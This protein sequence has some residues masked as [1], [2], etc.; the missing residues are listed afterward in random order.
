MGTRSGREGRPTQIKIGWEK[1][2]NGDI[3]KVL[4]ENIKESD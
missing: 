4:W 3:G 1:C 2:D